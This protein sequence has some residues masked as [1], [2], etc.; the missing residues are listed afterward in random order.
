MDSAKRR[1]VVTF[2]AGLMLLVPAIPASAGYPQPA[3]NCA[4]LNGE[5]GTSGGRFVLEF[6]GSFSVS[7]GPGCGSGTGGH[8]DGQSHRFT[9]AGS[10]FAVNAD[11]SFG[12][13]TLTLPSHMG[14]GPHRLFT[15]FNDGSEVVLPILVVGANETTGGGDTNNDTTGGG[16]GLASAANRTNGGGGGGL[17]PKTGGNILMLVLWAIA[18]IAA[19][20]AL[21]LAARKRGFGWQPL[22]IAGRARERDIVR[23]LPAPEIPFLDTTGFVPIRPGV[24]PLPPVTGTDLVTEAD[25]LQHRPDEGHR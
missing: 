2:F 18:L 3:A 4:D 25:L 1:V 19:G 21:V 24:V 20:T 8:V 12:S 16:G 7:G 14:P 10:N 13:P 11:G 9:F 23:A 15:V 6:L 17:L 5:Q 22:R